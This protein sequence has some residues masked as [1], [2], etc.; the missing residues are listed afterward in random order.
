[1]AAAHR[2]AEA[3]R[4]RHQHIFAAAPPARSDGGYS[5]CRAP[6]PGSSCEGDRQPGLPAFRVQAPQRKAREPALHVEHARPEQ[7]VTLDAQLGGPSI[8]PIGCTVEMSTRMPGPGCRPAN[9]ALHDRPA[10]PLAASLSIAAPACRKSR[11]ARSNMRETASGLT[12]GLSTEAQRMMPST[13]SCEE[14]FA[15]RTVH[16]ASRGRYFRSSQPPSTTTSLCASMK[17]PHPPGPRAT[18]PRPEGGPA[19]RRGRATSPCHVAR[20][21]MYRRQNAFLSSTLGARESIS[22]L[23]AIAATNPRP[24][25]RE[26]RCSTSVGAE[27]GRAS[28]RRG[29]RRRRRRPPRAWRLCR[30]PGRPAAMARRCVRSAV[31]HIAISIRGK[32]AFRSD[33]HWIPQAPHQGHRGL[34]KRPRL[35]ADLSRRPPLNRAEPRRIVATWDAASPKRPAGPPTST[36]LHLRIDFGDERSIGPGKIR[37]LEVDQGDRFDLCSRSRPLEMSSIARLGCWSD[38]LNQMFRSR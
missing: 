37:L 29:S 1:M 15:D 21:A 2:L 6:R 20:D 31:S 7:A 22:V 24:F 28:G 35:M 27:Q 10:R 18:P 38:E 8:V 12:D 33:R 25:P 4:L 32:T 13:I 9:R 34:R 17:G 36:S 26:N 3:R 16:Y 11:S 23:M 30:H 19:C 14:L 5:D